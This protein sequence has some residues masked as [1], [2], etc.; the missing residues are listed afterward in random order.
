MFR[1]VREKFSFT[2]FLKQPRNYEQGL[3]YIYLRITVDG[4]SK[5]L[6]VKGPGFPPD[7]APR[8]TGHRE[9][10]MIQKN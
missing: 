1:Y 3:M 6:S 10:K 5:E 2:V 9:Q 7:G 4:V 8:R